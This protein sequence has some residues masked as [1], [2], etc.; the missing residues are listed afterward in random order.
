MLEYK[1]ELPKSA[2]TYLRK[3]KNST[4]TI[5]F[6]TNKSEHNVNESF[7]KFIDL[8]NGQN[9]VKDIIEVFRNIYPQVPV[10][11]FENDI[12]D[13]I[14]KLDDLQV[15]KSDNNN[16]FLSKLELQL[17]ENHKICLANYTDFLKL[18]TL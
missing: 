4:C 10:S 17:N 2:I 14:V 7:V 18:K 1:P 3:E 11:T 5:K 12:L 6:I 13:M 16:P 15:L 8:F 9:S